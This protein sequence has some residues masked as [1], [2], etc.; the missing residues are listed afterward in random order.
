MDIGS[1]FIINHKN[2]EILVEFLIVDRVENLFKFVPVDY[3]PLVGYKDL[4]FGERVA[5]CGLQDFI[6]PEKLDEGMEVDF[7][8]RFAALVR[9]RLA[10]LARNIPFESDGADDADP[11]YS[12][13]IDEVNMLLGT[14]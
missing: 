12:D 14:I 7:D 13:H 4:Q 5:R 2:N 6:S 1:I 3:F 11:D 10:L 9:G 8:S